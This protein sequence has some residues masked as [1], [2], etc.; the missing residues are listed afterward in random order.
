MNDN[1]MLNK[2]VTSS[3]KINYGD[4]IINLTMVA[5]YTNPMDH[6]LLLL[7]DSS[8]YDLFIGLQ[9]HRTPVNIILISLY[10]SLWLARFNLIN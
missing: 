8:R 5:A 10:L 6:H 4:N 2:A 9:S 1:D 7:L 3:K